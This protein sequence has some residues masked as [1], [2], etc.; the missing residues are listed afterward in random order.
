MK[1]LILLLFCF[2]CFGS[3]T[4]QLNDGSTL[5]ITSRIHQASWYELPWWDHNGFPKY[6]GALSTYTAK[7][8]PIAVNG[9]GVDYY[10]FSENNSGDLNIYVADSL[11]NKTIVRTIS[12]VIDPHDNAVVNYWDGYI[13]VVAAARGNKRIGYSYRSKYKNDISEFI[14]VGS[15]YWAYPHLWEKALLYTVY[16]PLAV[17][18]LYS[19]TANC[20]QKLVSGG[21]YNISYDDG[22]TLHMVY[23]WHENSNLDMRTN[24][25]YMKSNDG[26]VWTDKDDNVLELPLSEFDNQTL[27]HSTPNNYTYLKDIHVIDGE[28]NI[29]TV[30]SDSFYP[31]EGNRYLHNFTLTNDTVITQVGHNYNTGAFVDGYIVTPTYGEFGYAGGDVEVFNLDGTHQLKSNFSYMYNYC[32]KVING[33]GCY[34]SESKSSK[35]NNS[36]YVRKITIN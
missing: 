22:D 10:T 34:V 3:A 6:S 4:R 1:Y 27:I 14:Q 30:V 25:Y 13:W 12:D 26:C 36:A 28:V 15:G 17:R 20:D 21:H 8:I 32:R 2:E 11:G 33:N 16:T 23:N 35:I 18:E 31:D 5:T 19:R 29:L 9:S 24:L 7:H